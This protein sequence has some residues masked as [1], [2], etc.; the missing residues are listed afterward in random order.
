[1]GITACV[2]NARPPSNQKINYAL[3]CGCQSTSCELSLTPRSIHVVPVHNH[4]QWL[5]ACQWQW[6]S[7]TNHRHTQLRRA[8]SGLI[9]VAGTTIDICH[10]FENRSV[11]T[12]SRT[13]H[14]TW[15][16]LTH[17]WFRFKCTAA[18][19]PNGPLEISA[20]SGIVLPLSA[21]PAYVVLLCNLD[22]S[23]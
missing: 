23:D 14:L 11:A 18:C 4:I 2:T 8:I 9:L 22:A 10:E 12:A 20:V 16:P 3:Q 6:Q 7:L 19:R 21:G 13:P 17:T 1:M 15:C 5:H